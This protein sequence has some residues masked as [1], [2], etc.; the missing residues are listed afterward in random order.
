MLQNSG[1]FEENLSNLFNYHAI[2]DFELD[3][4][5]IFDERGGLNCN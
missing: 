5:V 4:E 3:K 1:H 2:R